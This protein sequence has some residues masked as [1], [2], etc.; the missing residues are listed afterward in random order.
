MGA[1]L[2]DWSFV[3][4]NESELNWL[5]RFRITNRTVPLLDLGVRN[6][7]VEVPLP[8][9]KMREKLGAVARLTQPGEGEIGAGEN[10]QGGST[11][12]YLMQWFRAQLFPNPFP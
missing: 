7:K 2:S 5:F 11:P 6:M 12:S 8:K 9:S 3:T 1:D 10:E 4:G